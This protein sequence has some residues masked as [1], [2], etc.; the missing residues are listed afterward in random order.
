MPLHIFFA[1]PKLQFERFANAVNNNKSFPDIE[2][3]LAEGLRQFFREYSQQ[4]RRLDLLAG[5]WVSKTF[6]SEA[7]IKA[8]FGV[9]KSEPTLV[10]ESEIDGDYINF[11][12]AYWGLNWNDF[13]YDPIISRVPYRDI[14]LVLRI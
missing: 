10:L 13:R 3:T 14:L 9:L 11:R 5:A 6:H 2:L 12:I 1:P 7:S 8:L 4:N